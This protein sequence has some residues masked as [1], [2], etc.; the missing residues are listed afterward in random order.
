MRQMSSYPS[1]WKAC[2][3]MPKATG[4]LHMTLSINCPARR[5]PGYTPICIAKRVIIGIR[6]TGTQKQ[7]RLG[8]TFLWKQNGRVWSRIFWLLSAQIFGLIPPLSQ[9]FL[10]SEHAQHFCRFLPDFLVYRARNYP[11]Y[12]RQSDCPC[13]PTRL[14]LGFWCP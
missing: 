5:L 6:I 3:M 2:G 12:L 10:P 8:P 13:R 4:K 11:H 9:G 14:T 7:K 1:F